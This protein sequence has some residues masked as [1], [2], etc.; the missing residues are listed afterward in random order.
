MKI[1]RKCAATHKRLPT[2][3]QLQ[4]AFKSEGKPLKFSEVAP[5]LGNLRSKLM[6]AFVETR[7][8][9]VD[10]YNKAEQGTLAAWNGQNDKWDLDLWP[11]TEARFA[12]KSERVPIVEMTDEV[13]DWMQ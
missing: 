10:I 5:C 6:D 12:F 8:T 2:P 9:A 3:Q 7:I 11:S 4:A 1:G 13:A